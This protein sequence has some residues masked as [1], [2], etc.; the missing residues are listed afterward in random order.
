MALRY[1]TE[2]E[3]VNEIPVG[4]QGSLTDDTPNSET[5]VSAIIVQQGESA[6]ETV[7][8]YLGM[9]YT[10]PL[11][12]TDGTVPNS[13]K[14]AIFVLTKYYLYMRR[15]QV[16]GQM[17]AQYDTV[18]RWLKDIGA[19]RAGLNLLRSDGSVQSQGG[20]QINVSEQTYSQFNNFV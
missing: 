8:S 1:I 14:K 17:Q 9:I 11:I 6:E 10:I 15:D 2:A 16:D 19:G 13:L 12:A 7:E 4:L 5:A 20:S 18:L 3:L